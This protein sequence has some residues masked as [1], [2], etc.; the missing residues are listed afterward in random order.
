MSSIL[1]L[2]HLQIYSNSSL[3]SILL[4]LYWIIYHQRENVQCFPHLKNKQKLLSP[5]FPLANALQLCSSFQKNSMEDCICLPF[6]IPLL[7]FPLKLTSSLQVSGSA[8]FLS[9][10]SPA[11]CTVDHFPFFQSPL[12]SLQFLLSSSLTS[13]L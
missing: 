11:F 2:A 4:P 10:L 6:P 1:P 5:Q 13:L 12:L 3:P 8:L 7:P 9:D